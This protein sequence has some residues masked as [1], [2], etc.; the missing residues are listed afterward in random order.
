MTDP[1]EE[2]AAYHD[3]LYV[4]PERYQREALSANWSRR[5]SSAPDMTCSTSPAAP[6]ATS[7]TGGIATVSAGL[8]VSPAMLA[9][10]ASN[11]PD[12]EFHLADML[13]FNLGQDFDALMCLYGS[14][15]FVGTPQNLDK[16]LVAFAKH[17]KPGSILCLTPWSTREE[18]APTI[19][20]DLVRRPHIQILRME[21]VKLKEPGLVEVDF[22]HLVARDGQVSYHRQSIEIG[23]FSLQQYRN[24]IDR[25]RLELV[26]HRHGG[27]TRMGVFAARRP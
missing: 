26:E 22:H 17:L 27:G 14:I 15:G 1:F 21:N 3:D 18:F 20:T 25:T 23:L 5:T 8:D 16:T 2:I 11:F 4:K 19:V 24:A 7:P 10:A 6:A 13:D 12:V 9:L